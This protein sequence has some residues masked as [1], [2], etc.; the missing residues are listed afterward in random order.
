MSLFIKPFGLGQS[1]LE[2]N[3]VVYLPKTN[4]ML[5]DLANCTPY[6]LIIAVIE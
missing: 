4:R 6:H 2:N 5:L 3:T 1:E